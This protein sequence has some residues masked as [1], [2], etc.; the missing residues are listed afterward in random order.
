MQEASSKQQTKLQTQSS[1]DRITTSLNL[2]HQRENKQTNKISAQ[3]SPH[4]SL[5]Q[6]TGPTLEGRNQKE[7][8]VQPWSLE[9]GDLKNNKLKK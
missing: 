4:K 5:T 7:E 6:I 8:R 2:A 1:V 3:I 9:K